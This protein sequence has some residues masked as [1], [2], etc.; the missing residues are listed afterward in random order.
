VGPRAG[1]G[2]GGWVGGGEEK[3]H[4]PCR[5]SNPCRPARSLVSILIG[6]L[7]L[8][9]RKCLT[10]VYVIHLSKSLSAAPRLYLAFGLMAPIGAKHVIFYRETS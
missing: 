4:S 3:S 5:K 1:V 9:L 6:L 7:L 10:P 8:L 2:C